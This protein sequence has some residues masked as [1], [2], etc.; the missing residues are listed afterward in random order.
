[1]LSSILACVVL[2]SAVDGLPVEPIVL[3]GATDLSGKPMTVETS[4]SKATVLLFISYECPIANRYVPEIGRIYADYKEKGVQFYRVYV[5]DQDLAP[6]CVQ[7]G[8][9]FGIK[10][11]GLIDYQRSLAKMVGATVTPEAAVLDTDGRL[12]YRGRI[13]N[14][15]V[16]HGKIREGYRRDLR[17]ALDEML[18]GKPVSMPTSAAIG[19]FINYGQ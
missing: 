11:P 8:K 6:E 16:E 18:A 17:V 2:S 5:N 9:D 4:G 3:A 7:H 12:Q 14:Q 1:M 10:M 13:D 15:N 19:C